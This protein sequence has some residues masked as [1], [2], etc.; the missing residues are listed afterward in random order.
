MDSQD[1]H[2]FLKSLPSMEFRDELD[3]TSKFVPQFAQLLGYSRPETFYEFRAQISNERRSRFRADAAFSK[4]I[5][6]TPWLVIEMKRREREDVPADWVAQVR[7]LRSIFA[8]PTA[9]LVTPYFLVIASEG[10]EHEYELRRL[11][12][13]QATDIFDALQRHAQAKRNE[14]PVVTPTE[15]IQLIERVEKAETNDDKGKS[16]EALAAFLLGGVPGLRCK[17]SNLRTRSSEI[18]LVVEYVPS[19]RRLSLFD[20]VGQYALVECKNWSRPVGADQVRNFISK[21]DK[22]KARLGVIFAKNGITGEADGTAAL[23]EIQSDFD[24]HGKMVLVFSLQELK[25]ID[26]GPVFYDVLDLKADNLRF[27][28]G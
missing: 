16:L 23:R 17:Y 25:S 18:D 9:L 8:A 10:G 12:S 7:S 24:R 13:Q 28:I 5:E 22:C 27:D 20:E 14:P 6:G 11:T 26:S 15:L 2:A 1:L 21:L 4:S 19:T 3:F